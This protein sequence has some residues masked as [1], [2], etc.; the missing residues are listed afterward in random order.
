LPDALVLATAAV[1]G[2]DRVPTTDA[3]W[4]AIGVDVRIIEPSR[5]KR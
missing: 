5:A 1:L 4:P 2:A 3:G